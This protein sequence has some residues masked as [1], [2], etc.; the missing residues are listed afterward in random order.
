MLQWVV[1]RISG[2]RKKLRHPP[3]WTNRWP[4]IRARFFEIVDIYRPA[5]NS[6]T[7][8]SVLRDSTAAGGMAAAIRPRRSGPR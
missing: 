7:T 3:K 6:G 8:L 4:L 2:L 5:G 1:A